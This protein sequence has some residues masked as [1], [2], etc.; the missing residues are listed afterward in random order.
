MLI[1][2]LKYFYG[3][4]LFIIFRQIQTMVQQEVTVV[5]DLASWIVKKNLNHLVIF[6]FCIAAFVYTTYLQRRIAN[7]K[8]S[9]LMR[10]Y[11][12]IKKYL[13]EMGFF[14]SCKG[15]NNYLSAIVH[16]T[17]MAP[18][19]LIVSTDPEIYIQLNSKKV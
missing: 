7:V 12:W 16:S 13:Q 5:K 3:F 11:T 8:L 18:L 1:S 2:I 17:F 6:P 15:L 9:D 10:D 14:L 19:C 4:T